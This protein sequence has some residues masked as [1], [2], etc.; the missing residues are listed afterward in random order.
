MVTSVSWT[1]TTFVDTGL[2]Y[3]QINKIDIECIGFVNIWLV[4][5]LGMVAVIEYWS[6]YAGA[7]DAPNKSDNNK[8]KMNV[9]NCKMFAR[10]SLSSRSSFLMSFR[11]FGV[12]G[13][14]LSVTVALVVY[15]DSTRS[16]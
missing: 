14:S 2:A 13:A 8:P 9:V 3:F 11:R 7:T 16:M 10:T 15:F 5:T 12:D 4:N 1:M 6:T